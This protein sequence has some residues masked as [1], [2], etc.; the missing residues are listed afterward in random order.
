MAL[1]TTAIWEME[2]LRLSTSWAWVRGSDTPTLL[3]YP[4]GSIMGL[5][6]TASLEIPIQAESMSELRQ[7]IDIGDVYTA[8]DSRI[9][10]GVVG[11]PSN[12][13][14]VST[15]PQR[16]CVFGDPGTQ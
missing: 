7:A 16:R 4:P 8:R 9:G 6:S 3:S 14:P 13:R 12:L 2:C 10:S 1:A 5:T 11:Q 15:P